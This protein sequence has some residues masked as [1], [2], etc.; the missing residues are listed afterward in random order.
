VPGLRLIATSREPLGIPRRRPGA[1]RRAGPAGRS[2]AVHWPRPGRAAR[3]PGRRAGW[4]RSSRTSAAGSTICPW[5]LSSPPPVCVRCRWP[6]WPNGSATASGCSRGVPAPPCPASRRSGR[7]WT[8]ATT[9]CSRTNAACSPGWRCSVA[10]AP[11]RGRSRLC[12]RAGAGR[13]DPRCA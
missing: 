2:R 11:G 12:R 10:A 1:R 6:P 3:L 7:W 13:R 9:C 5:P 4:R 8:G